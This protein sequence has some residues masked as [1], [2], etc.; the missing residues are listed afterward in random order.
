MGK[1]FIIKYLSLI[2]SLFFVTNVF[3]QLGTFNSELLQ[4]KVLRKTIKLPYL[5]MNSYY[6]YIDSEK[7]PDEVRGGK[8]YYY[9]Y[10]WIPLAVPEIGIRMVSPIP[11]KMKPKSKDFASETFKSNSSERV[12]YFDTWISLEKAS[13]VVSKESA[14]NNFETHEWNQISYNDDSSELP[15]QPSGN[16]YNSLL[17]KISDVNDPL[18]SLTVGLYRI[19]FT[20]YKKGKVEGSFIAQIGATIK[21]P[22]VMIV[23]DINKLME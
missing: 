7:S 9:L 16:S 17:R 1:K 3:S 20:T 15:K 22:G 5:D 14:V 18:N 21:I 11:S 23:E 4:K 12:K 6:G 13:N 2:F 19:G 8:S 10:V